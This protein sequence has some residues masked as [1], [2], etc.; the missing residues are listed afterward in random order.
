MS[1]EIA[2]GILAKIAPMAA[3]AIG[4]PFGPLIGAGLSSILGTKDSTPESITKALTNGQLTG[5]Q[6]VA[7]QKMETDLKLQLEQL[8]IKTKEDLQQFNLEMEKVAAGDRDSARERE[9][10]TGD[11]WTPRIIAG[12]VVVSW[13]IIQFILIWQ[14]LHGGHVFPAEMVG[15]I[16]RVLGTLDMALGL[17][18]AYYFGGIHSDSRTKEMLYNS[19]P[20]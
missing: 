20:T 5:D 4:G 15:P 19:T 8:N 17:V 11:S 16:M 18:L 3:V 2:K 1:W 12:L 10:K 9:I 14:A 7:I 13:I 6:I